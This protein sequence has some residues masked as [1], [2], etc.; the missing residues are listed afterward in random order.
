MHSY[1]FCKINFFNRPNDEPFINLKLRKSI[2]KKIRKIR[3]V[4]CGY[5]NATIQINAIKDSTIT[6]NFFFD[7]N[8]N[9]NNSEEI[10]FYNNVNIIFHNWAILHYSYSPIEKNFDFKRFVNKVDFSPFKKIDWMMEKK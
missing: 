2:W 7:Y 8:K 6:S 5:T 9:F 10:N 3:V 1:D 4:S